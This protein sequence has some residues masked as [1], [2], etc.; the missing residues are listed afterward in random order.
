VRI[1]FIYSTA[2]VARDAIVQADHHHAAPMR[3][4]LVELVELVA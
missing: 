4:F 3:A 1:R 2:G